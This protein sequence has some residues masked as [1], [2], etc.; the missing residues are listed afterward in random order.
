MQ[1]FAIFITVFIGMASGVYFGIKLST[2][3]MVHSI[4]TIKL[5]EAMDID[6]N[7]IQKLKDAMEFLKKNK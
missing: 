2:R 7:D 4:R 1:L 6:V 5:I 3:A